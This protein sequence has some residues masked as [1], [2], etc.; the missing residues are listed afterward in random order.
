LTR[1]KLIHKKLHNLL[2]V[3][4]FTVAVLRRFWKMLLPCLPMAHF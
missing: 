4:N 1:E 3:A 2:K